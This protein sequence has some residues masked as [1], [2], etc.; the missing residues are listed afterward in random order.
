MPF[1]IIQA[2]KS[3]RAYEK[4]EDP[5]YVLEKDIPLDYE[6][7]IE[8]QLKKPISRIFKPILKDKV[9]T[10]FSGEHT[11]SITI[12]T[13]KSEAGGISRFIKKT[14]QCLCCKTSLP[15]GAKPIC[16]ACREQGR[17]AE[18]YNRQIVVVKDLEQKYSRAWT[19]CQKCM[20]SL[21]S[22]VKC[23]K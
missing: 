9:N 20:G 12:T 13:P 14:F 11:R 17:E 2:L 19:Q 8:N 22:K 21:H 23:T 7:Y 10:L 1:V 16:Q 18:F 4:A 3:S 15:D 5:L 6:Y